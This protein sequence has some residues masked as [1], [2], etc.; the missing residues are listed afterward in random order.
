MPAAA[1]SKKSKSKS[2]RFP[3]ARIKKIMQM[4]EEVGK[5][6][7]ATPVMISKSLECFL[8]SFIDELSKDAEA[9]GSRKIT[10]H[11]LKSTVTSQ[12][13]FDFLLPLVQNIADPVQAGGGHNGEGGAQRQRRASRPGK[14]K[15]VKEEGDEDEYGRGGASGSGSV[16]APG[17][18]SKTLP[19]IGTWKR[20][21]EGAGGTGEG[22][23]GM[24]D[25]YEAD[26]DDY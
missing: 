15:A 7:S 21:M 2:S 1:S 22:G 13:N 5:L 17:D 24:Y 23:R 19:Q 6:A 25:D 8:Q 12:P 4:D 10:P 11:H 26:E 14:R 9:R 20:E 18:A 3:V 16:P